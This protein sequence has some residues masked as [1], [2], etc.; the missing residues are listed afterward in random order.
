MQDN[1]PQP[2]KILHRER[3]VK[4]QLGTERGGLLEIRYSISVEH[5]STGKNRFRMK[6]RRK[7][8]AIPQ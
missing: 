4:P 1:A 7:R 5:A 2:V 6:V 3:L 8:N